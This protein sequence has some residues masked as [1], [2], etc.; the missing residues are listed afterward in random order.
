VLISV[1]WLTAYNYTNKAFDIQDSIVTFAKLAQNY[2]NKAFALQSG[3]VGFAELTYNYTNKAFDLQD[4][5][6]I[7]ASMLN[8]SGNAGFDSTLYVTGG[9]VG[10]GTTN[11]TNKLN[12]YKNDALTNNPQIRIE[13]EGTGD[14]NIGFAITGVTGWTLGI[15]NDD[16]DKFKISYD[17]SQL[18]VNPKLI[19]TSGGNVGIGT[20]SPGT[21]LHVKSSAQTKDGGIRLE[22][23]GE[24]TAWDFFMDTANQLNIQYH[25]GSSPTLTIAN[26]K[27]GIGTT[28]PQSKLHLYTKDASTATQLLRL[29]N[30]DTN[31]GAGSYLSYYLSTIEAGRILSNHT[32]SGVVDMIFSTY[33]SGLQESMVITGDG[34]VG[35]G[36]TT[37]SKMLSVSSGA[38]FFNVSSTG[39]VYMTGNITFPS[40]GVIWDN[41]T[42]V[43]WE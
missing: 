37:P 29:E 38:N 22:D 35:I 14:A 20:T 1:T 2:T 12:I 19:I 23:Y 9:K 43:I 4:G 24:T 42:H 40:G 21:P 32:S 36:T 13:N 15:D 34:K 31:V 41:G 16:D 33:N 8:S 28:N 10:I 6:D 27:V 17:S 25:T 39:D 5:I 11:P 3:I 30:N 18:G 7:Y 26:G